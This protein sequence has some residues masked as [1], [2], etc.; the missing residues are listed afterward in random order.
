MPGHQLV[1]GFEIF[2]AARG[3][4]A[5]VSAWCGSGD[6]LESGCYGAQRAGTMVFYRSRSFFEISTKSDLG[7]TLC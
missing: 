6:V 3:A 5:S 2:G 1:L 7:I 4:P